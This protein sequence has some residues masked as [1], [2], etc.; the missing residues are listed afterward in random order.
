MSGYE[1][2]YLGSSV[3]NGITTSRSKNKKDLVW[4]GQTL[5]GGGYFEE[6][7]IP[8]SSRLR[9]GSKYSLPAYIPE[10][11]CGCVCGIHHKKLQHKA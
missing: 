4:E 8:P 11:T 2:N 5:S 1:S 6:M 10:T 9:G 3:C 7:L